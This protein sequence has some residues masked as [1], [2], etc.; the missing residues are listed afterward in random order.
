MRL[1]PET[2]VGPGE[3]THLLRNLPYITAAAAALVLA[4]VP[5]ARADPDPGSAYIYVS[6]QS[7]QRLYLIDGGKVVFESPVNT[8]IRAAP[9]PDGIFRIFASYP[10]KTMKGTD[11]VTLKQYND[12]NVPY[13]MYFDGGRAIHGFYRRGYGYPQSLGCVELPVYK[14]RELY[15]LVQGGL[16]TEVV[17]AERRPSFSRG[18]TASGEAWARRV[19]NKGLNPQYHVDIGLAVETTQWPIE[20]P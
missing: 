16:A 17:V 4:W 19:G 2:F 18:P 8:G 14:A 13:A 3:M 1:P 15:Q 12:P 5:G 7:P 9:T 6:K 10:Q 11:P 20:R